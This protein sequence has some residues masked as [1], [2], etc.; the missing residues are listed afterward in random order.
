MRTWQVERRKRTRQ[1]IELGGLVLK[2]GIVELTND[3]R[4]IIYG[5]MLWI[6]AKLQGHDGKHARELLAAKGK[7]AFDGERR[8]EQMDWRT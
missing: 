5:A 7:Q 1:L 6:A 2:A 4:A 3:D 8:E